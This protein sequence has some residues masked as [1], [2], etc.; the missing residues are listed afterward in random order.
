[1]SLKI[2]IS[3]RAAK[4]FRSVHPH[5]ARRIKVAIAELA[6]DPRPSGSKQLVGGEG[7]MRIRVGDYRIVYEIIDEQLIVLVLRIGHRREIYR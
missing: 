6:N 5:A 7:E 2:V 1:M 4:V 3:P